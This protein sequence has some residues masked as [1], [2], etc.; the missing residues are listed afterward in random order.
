MGVLFREMKFS[1]RTQNWSR[2]AV[3]GKLAGRRTVKWVFIAIRTVWRRTTERI[4]KNTSPVIQFPVNLVEQPSALQLIRRETK[5]R[6]HSHEN[7]AIPDLQ[8]PFDG[9]ENFH[10][11][12]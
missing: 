6:Q 8:P 7:Q 3:V 4:G 11:M 10:S 1:W 5:S 2:R 12:Q 9:F